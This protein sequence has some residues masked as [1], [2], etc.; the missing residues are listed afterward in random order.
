M[1]SLKQALVVIG[2]RPEA[3]KLAPVARAVLSARLLQPVICS[4]GQHRDLLAE[5]LRAFGLTPGVSL[6]LMRP[7]QTPGEVVARAV[8]A[9]SAVIAAQPPAVIVV[10]GDTASAFAGALAGFYAGI[11][12]AHVEAGLRT[13]SI[14]APFP[15]EGHRRLVSRLAALHYAPT[16]QARENLVREG[17]PRSNVL[18]TGN[19][20]IDALLAVDRTLDRS[21]R[22]RA[23]LRQR[24][25]FVRPGRRLVMVTAHRRENLGEPLARICDALAYVATQTDADILFPVH[26]NPAVGA[27]ARARLAAVPN[28]HLTDPLEYADCVWLL[29][30]AHLI[31]TDS[32]GLQEEAT[33]LGVPLL[34]LR[35]TTERNEGVEA[36]VAA[37]VGTDPVRI[38]GATLALLRDEGVRS[39]M[40]RPLSVY[41]AGGAA[42][43][44]ARDLAH[45]YSACRKRYTDTQDAVAA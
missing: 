18:L 38:A 35:E 12:V 44:I 34:V 29:R 23:T 10:Q 20:G 40:A 31:L 6:D 27:I 22:L 4:T 37:L 17:I 33:T 16:E 19:T 30:Q 45:R 39:A 24:Y 8:E 11:P 25:P 21:L 7:D 3:I 9:I 2:T 15:E 42:A 14:S 28:V 5:A 13:A 1:A 26:P 32:G 43:L 41:G 36:G